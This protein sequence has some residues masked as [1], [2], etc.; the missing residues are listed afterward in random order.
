MVVYKTTNL[1]NGKWY[2]GQD[3][4]NSKKILCVDNGMIFDSI[5]KASAWCVENHKSTNRQS[6]R[7]VCNGKYKTAGGLNWSWYGK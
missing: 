2:I 4:S 5:I 1:I 6:I 7:N 3:Q